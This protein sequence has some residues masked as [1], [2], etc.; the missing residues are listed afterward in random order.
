M[1]KVLVIPDVHLRTW[2]F[3]RAA[4]LAGGCD[5]VVVLGDLVDDWGK[6]DDRN[7]Y[8]DTIAA[9]KEFAASH[10]E[11]LWCYGNH[12]YCYLHHDEGLYNTGFSDELKYF[13]NARL[14]ELEEVVGD[15]YKIIHDIDGVLFSHAG[16]GKGYFNSLRDRLGGDLSLGEC[17]EF[18]NEVASST[19]L[20]GDD[21]PLW[22]RPLQDSHDTAGIEGVPQVVGHTPV[23]K[24][25]WADGIL[26]TD[27]F[28]VHPN[29]T[30]LGTQSFIIYDT[31][32][33]D[34][35]EA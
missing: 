7:A 13:V 9:A 26:I 4:R 24:P 35:E 30:P 11:S 10:P 21:S 12:D 25:T 20:W 1:S 18:T 29:G 22:Y 27:T 2:M 19:I 32:T 28:S 23:P 15:R 6:E 3:E 17:I 34:F 16:V 31:E 14:R 33:H 8:A 5:A